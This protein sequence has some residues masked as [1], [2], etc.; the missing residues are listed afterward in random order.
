MP[1]DRILIE[2][3]MHIAG[4]DMDKHLEDIARKIF[5]LKSWTEHEGRARLATNWKLFIFGRER[6]Q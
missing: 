3:D 6:I 2:S 4:A 5:E 1:E